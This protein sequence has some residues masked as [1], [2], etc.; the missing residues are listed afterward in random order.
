[1][2]APEIIHASSVEI[3]AKFKHWLATECR[4]A[5]RLVVLEGLTGSGKSTL[6]KQPFSL[7]ARLSTNIALD[8]FL[9]ASVPCATPYVDALDRSA[10]NAAI[11]AAIGGASPLVIVEG[12]VAWPFVQAWTET[13]GL[14]EV[15]RVYLKR[16]MLAKPDY[17]Q[18]EH[19]ILYPDW[20]PSTEYDRSIYRYHANQRPWLSAGLVLERIEAE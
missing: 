4:A 7:G 5:A 13:I 2:A 8:Q 1:M 9:P 18:D 11:N 10:M 14:G 16:M 20:W 19:N 6:T 15:R 12:A 17:W 3:R